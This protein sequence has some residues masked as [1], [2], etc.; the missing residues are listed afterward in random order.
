MKK[1]EENPRGYLKL[2]DVFAFSQDGGNANV[3]NPLAKDFLT[4]IEDGTLSSEGGLEAEKIL[5]INKVISSWRN[6]SKRI[7]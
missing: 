2:L 4:K 3:G 5:E 7:L 6:S 1:K